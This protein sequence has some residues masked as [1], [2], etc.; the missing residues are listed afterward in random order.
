MKHYHLYP[1]LLLFVTLLSCGN[2]QKAAKGPQHLT[3]MTYN[4]GGFSKY[5]DNSTS[6][7]AEIIR[8]QGASYV[9]L[10]ETDSL[11]NRHPAY[12]VKDL[13]ATLGADWN[14]HFGRAMAYQGGAYG[15]GVVTTQ[16]IRKRYRIALPKGEGAE[17]RSAAVVETDQ[18][19]FASVHLDHRSQAAALEQMKVVN[20][21]F[22]Q[23][24]NGCKKP[25]FLCGD[26]NVV[27]ESEVITLA[28]TRWTLLSGTR[29]THSTT[30]PKHCIDYIFAYKGAVPVT[31]E[32]AQVITEGTVELSDHFPVVISVKF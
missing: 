22:D 6:G 27:P 2:C 9:S 28:K 25:V 3:L 23:V 1:L 29:N 5:M 8:A 30:N 14:Y 24:Y 15:N 20:N 16:P 11:T 10:N 7:V 13:A 4:V 17:P 32:S 31:V 12:Q 19:V 26:F 21:W 18:C